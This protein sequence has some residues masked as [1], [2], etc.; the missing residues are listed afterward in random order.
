MSKRRHFFMGFIALAAT[1]LALS[2]WVS[3]QQIPPAGKGKGVGLRPSDP[4][5][6][7][8]HEGFT[9][10]FDGSTLINWDGKPGVWRVEDGAIVGESTREKPAGNTFIIYTGTEV[11]D[12]DLKLEVKLEN[13]G[14]GIQYRS[15]R[16]S[17]TAGGGAGK[18]VPANDPRWS[19][20]GPQMDFWSPIANNE[21]MYTG[22]LFSQGG[23]GFQAW[24]G[25]VAQLTSGKRSRV[26]GAVGDPEALGGYQRVPDWNQIMVVVRGGTFIHILNGHLMSVLVDDD[27]ASSN[28]V[29]GLIG[30]QIEGPPPCKVSVRNIWLKKLP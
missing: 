25:E 3:A 18:A 21:R 24:R 10:I 13:S 12:F 28:N 4:L 15:S 26:I 14:S 6:F 2:F 1:Y 20:V 9:K 29:S 17:Q 7:N 5:D 27:P 11:K 30:V 16:R 22:T 8:D 19:M 23:G